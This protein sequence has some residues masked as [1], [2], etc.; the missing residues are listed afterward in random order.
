MYIIWVW[1]GNGGMTQVYYVTGCTTP[2]AG[3]RLSSRPRALTLL[4]LAFTR[5]GGTVSKTAWVLQVISYIK[6]NSKWLRNCLT[7]IVRWPIVLLAHRPVLLLHVWLEM[8]NKYVLVFVITA[9]E[10]LVQTLLQAHEE[11]GPRR[12][13]HGV[14]Q[15]RRD[16]RLRVVVMRGHLHVVVDG[17]RVRQGRP[18]EQRHVGR[19]A[20]AGPSS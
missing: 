17:R 16:H 3:T 11:A 20:P 9:D 4:K 19:H 15:N 12:A 6:K 2:V 10:R 5:S 7:L 14:A 8:L 1:M 18:Q 13:R